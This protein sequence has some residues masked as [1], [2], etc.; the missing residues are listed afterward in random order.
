[1][2]RRNIRQEYLGD[3]FSLVSAGL[4]GFWL[5]DNGLHVMSIGSDVLVGNGFVAINGNVSY[6]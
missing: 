5:F 3:D 6:I 1:M 4:T 2:A